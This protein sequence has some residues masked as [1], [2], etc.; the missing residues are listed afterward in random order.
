MSS[1]TT[2]AAHR[3]QIEVYRRMSGSRRVEIAAQMSEDARAIAVAGIRRRHPRYT[4]AELR[5]ALMRLLLGDDLFSRAWPT[6]PL[7]DG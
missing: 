4:E 1:D 6:S 5:H 2:D 3:A 7:V